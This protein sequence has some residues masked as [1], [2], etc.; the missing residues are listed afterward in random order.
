LWTWGSG[1]D[2]TSNQVNK[3][4][5]DAFGAVMEVNIDDDATE[6]G[7][8]PIADSI[9]T[10]DRWTYR[11]TPDGQH[12]TFDVTS[13]ADG[14]VDE[15]HIYY[16]QG[17]FQTIFVADP[18][19]A[20]VIVLYLN[21]SG[22]YTETTGIHNWGWEDN[23][24][25]WG[26]PLPME[27][28]FK[29]P[30]GLVGIGAMLQVL[31]ANITN[32]PGIIVHDG[33]TKYS[34][35]DNIQFQTDG[36]TSFFDGMVAGEVMVI[37]TG[38]AG[39]GESEYGYTLERV[40]F[41]DELMNFIKGDAIWGYVDY[42]K[43]E[44]P[45]VEIDLTPFFSLWDGETELTGAIEE[46]NYNVEDDAITELVV[47]LAEGH[48]LEAGHEYILKFDNGEEDLLKQQVAEID[49]DIDDEAPVITFISDQEVSIIAG[50]GWDSELWPVL[51]AEDDR[52]GMVT[53]RIYVKTGDGEVDMNEVGVHEVILTVFDVWGNESTA[54]FT[55][56]VLEPETGCG[57]ASASIAGIGVV[58]IVL[59]FVKRKE[60]I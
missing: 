46:L 29:N 52:D 13:I 12:I 30:A 22:E 58:G 5:V 45:R 17:G 37:Y 8:I 35:N 48:E 10:D 1:A 32:N 53:D 41:V 36:T 6:I 25:G 51:R 3:V 47:V 28:A 16:F 24:V 43:E 15:I 27:A 18:T 19:M 2:G 44:Y 33:D 31:P 40:D 14:T 7:L 34:G 49:V 39:S 56:N 38:I 55:I 59:F 54:V 11:E 4:G 20:N 26:E 50:E 57:A 42:E 21:G 23:A 9:G 60:L